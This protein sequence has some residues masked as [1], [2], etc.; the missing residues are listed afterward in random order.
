[1]ASP[2]CGQLPWE[3]SSGDAASFVI[4]A[5]PHL[6]RI[7]LESSTYAA[8]CYGQTKG[9]CDMFISQSLPYQVDKQASCPFQERICKLENDNLLLETGAID[10]LEHLGLNDGPRF[11]V[12]HRMH[13]APLETENYTK[14][15][16]LQGTSSRS[17]VKYFYGPKDGENTTFTMEVPTH[18]RYK[19]SNDYL[20]M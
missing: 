2:N 20:I 12:H 8:Q 3:H 15:V 16:P 19:E 1:M 7:V 10:S 18:E 4:T 5:V 13:C 9:A 14:T 17:L 6:S 11:T